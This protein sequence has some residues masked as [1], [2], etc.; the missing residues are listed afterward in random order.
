MASV[1]NT[2][3][4]TALIASSRASEQDAWQPLRNLLTRWPY[5]ADFAVVVGNASGVQFTHLH[6]SM[7][8]DTHVATASTSKWPMAMALT[9]LV[10]DGTIK[11]L[12][13]RASDYISWW[14][15]NASDPRSAVTLRHLL[16]FTSGFGNGQPGNETEH[17]SP[18]LA[19]VQNVSYESC[20]REVYEKTDVWGW[21]GT[22]YSYNSNHLKLAGMMAIAASGL[23]IQAV[24]FKYLNKGLGMESTIC[25]GGEGN[26]S[27]I[28]VPNPDLAVCLNTT[29]ADYASFLTGSSPTKHGSQHMRT[30]P[31]KAVSAELCFTPMPRRS[32]A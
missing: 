32:S 16:S 18:C 27:A 30:S 3:A 14:T 6:G 11:S 10:A 19:M 21:P 2:L 8:L 12:D 31:P 24:I 5:T 4:V 20:A 26:S 23:D 29:G 28:R 1:L 15:T 7:T 9:G 25:G 22:V 13:S 17:S